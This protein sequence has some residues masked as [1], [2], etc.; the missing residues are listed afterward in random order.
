[1]MSLEASLTQ[2][3]LCPDTM[4][5]PDCRSTNFERLVDNYEKKDGTK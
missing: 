1:M 5:Q 3:K 2:R 4:I